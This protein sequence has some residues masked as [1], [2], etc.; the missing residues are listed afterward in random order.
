MGLEDEVGFEQEEEVVL[1]RADPWEQNQSEKALPPAWEWK[2]S[3][4]AWRA[5]GVKKEARGN[6]ALTPDQEQ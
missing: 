3:P 6:G 1:Q 2:L 5:R 4:C